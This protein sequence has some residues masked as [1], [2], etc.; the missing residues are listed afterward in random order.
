MI[1]ALDPTD[2]TLRVKWD[3]T[4]SGWDIEKVKNASDLVKAFVFLDAWTDDERVS[5]ITY[6]SASEGLTF[7]DTFSYTLI[8][9]I[10]WTPWT[11]LIDTI[12]TS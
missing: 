9:W 3:I 8:P 7:T 10:P 2:N 6:T 12:V 11:Y 4:V 1:E 5:T